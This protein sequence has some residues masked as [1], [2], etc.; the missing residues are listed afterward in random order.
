M[1]C[2]LKEYEQRVLCKMLKQRPLGT[3]GVS[4]QIYM[5]AAIQAQ[6]SKQVERMC[7]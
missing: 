4:M 1:E 2:S 7:I 3:Q 6:G 5:G